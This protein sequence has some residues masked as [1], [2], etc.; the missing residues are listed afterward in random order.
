MLQDLSA[1]GNTWT[2]TEIDGIDADATTLRVLA[3]G[4]KNDG[5]F[6]YYFVDAAVPEPGGAALLVLAAWGALVRRPA[7]RGR[8]M[9]TRDITQ[10]IWRGRD[11]AARK[12][13]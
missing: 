10:K 7:G 12:T 9:E 13:T 4:S 11:E 6:N 8:A 2:F 1:D 3:V 5:P